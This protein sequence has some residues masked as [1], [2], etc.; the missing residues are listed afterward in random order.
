MCIKKKTP[1]VHSWAYI[2]SDETLKRYMYPSIHCSTIHNSQ[3]TQ[4]T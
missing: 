3:D 1:M 4:V 2:Y